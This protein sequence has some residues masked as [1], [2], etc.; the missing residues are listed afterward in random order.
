[1]ININE[2]IEVRIYE[3]LKDFKKYPDKYLTESDVRCA[4]VRELMKINDLNRLQIT[5]DCSESIPIHTE[6][7]WYGQ[8]GKLKWRSDI[9]A[10]DVS[11][12]KVRDGLFR[13]PSKGYGFNFPKAI[14]E[15]K[16]RRINGGSSKKFIKK[17]EE[18]IRKLSNI[19]NEVPGDYFCCLVALDKKQNIP[20]SM[21]PVG[22]NNI[23]IYYKFAR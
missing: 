21:L 12:L 4:L 1:M 15:I 23:H 9:V 8:S 5:E 18:D 6:V 11:T 2:Q 17:I 14:I 7:R 22:N 10:I 16:L 13:L 19:I 20:Q 3:L